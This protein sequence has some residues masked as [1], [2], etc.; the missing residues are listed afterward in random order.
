MTSIDINGSPSP[1]HNYVGRARCCKPPP[2]ADDAAEEC[3]TEAQEA[4]NPREKDGVE[5]EAKPKV[6][7]IAATSVGKKSSNDNW[8]HTEPCGTC[9]KGQRMHWYKNAS[10]ECAV[11]RCEE[12]PACVD[13]SET[14]ATPDLGS[15]SVGEVFAELGPAAES[16]GSIRCVGEITRATARLS[17]YPFK[18]SV[19]GAN[20]A[21]DAYQRAKKCRS[22]VIDAT[23]YSTPHK[24][25]TPYV[26]CNA[27]PGRTEPPGTPKSPGWYGYERT[28]TPKDRERE[29]RRHVGRFTRLDVGSGGSFRELCDRIGLRCKRVIDWE[30]ARKSCGSS[31]EDGSRLARC[32]K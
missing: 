19:R 1:T 12:D 32:D 7:L 13:A 25:C 10:E 6:Q 4:H 5:A 27:L 16:N 28:K 2:E 14:I 17:K 15:E 31:A 20:S 26:A 8:C 23:Y 22:D 21:T 3:P 18:M 24:I 30:G 29:L 11:S 9:P